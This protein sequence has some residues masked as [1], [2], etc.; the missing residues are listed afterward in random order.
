LTIEPPSISYIISSLGKIYV[1]VV[2]AVKVLLHLSYE[3]L[4]QNQIIGSVAKNLAI[5]QNQ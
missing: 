1:V 4:Q 3:F 5:L 2:V